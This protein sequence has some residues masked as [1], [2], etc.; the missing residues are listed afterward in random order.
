MKTLAWLW[1]VASASLSC[2]SARV[3]DS[4]DGS[5][6]P[7]V[8]GALPD[9][10]RGPDGSLAP[11]A[12][13]TT[14]AAMGDS[15]VG[16]A[17]PAGLLI[18][19]VNPNL[20]LGRDLIELRVT[21]AGTLS[22]MKLVNGNGGSTLAN[23]PAICAAA[24]DIVVVHLSPAAANGNAAASETTSKSQYPQSAA[25]ANYD[26]AWDVNQDVTAAG[27]AFTETILI[28]RRMDSSVL[29]V[30]VFSNLDG[31]SSATYMTAIATQQTAGT[32]LPAT[33]A[34]TQCQDVAADFSTVGDMVTLPSIQR[35][36]AT[37]THTKNDWMVKAQTFGSGN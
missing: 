10:P 23:L 28:M 5:V 36:G 30:A 21:T 35:V 9:A 14:D 27:I 17:S 3:P 34:N 13:L 24:G 20:A 22:G 12:A 37:D 29:D 8:D 4:D 26:G 25:S 2:A 6:S 1:A 15:T 31:T 18:N 32:W 19:E 7:P 11:D 16:C 33:C